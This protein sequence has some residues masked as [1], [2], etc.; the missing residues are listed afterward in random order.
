MRGRNFLKEVSP[1]RPL[2][3]NFKN[4]V[5]TVGYRWLSKGVKS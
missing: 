1:P 5:H 4:M 3:K 2:F